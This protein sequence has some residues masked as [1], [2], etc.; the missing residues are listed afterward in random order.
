MYHLVANAQLS[1]FL[2]FAFFH[3]NLVCRPLV[4]PNGIVG[5]IQVGIALGFRL[6]A[7]FV[8]LG[9]FG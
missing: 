6:W 7:I 8:C 1:G 4:R 9:S 5:V 3:F 2:P